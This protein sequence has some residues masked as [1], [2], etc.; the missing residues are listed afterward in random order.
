[1]LSD[2]TASGKNTELWRQ[3]E[4]I[5][6]AYGVP[7]IRAENLRA[8]GYA[9]AWLQLEDYG[10]TTAMNVLGA[11]GSAASVLGY[12][13]IDGDFAVLAVQREQVAAKYPQLSKDV[14]D[15]YEGFAE[16]I[17]RFIALHPTEFPAEMPA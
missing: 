13:R 9:L 2:K 3:V 4:V 6:T 14:R 17:N 11:S 16:G 5:R 12:E 8:A 15:I 1:L 7:H 10:T